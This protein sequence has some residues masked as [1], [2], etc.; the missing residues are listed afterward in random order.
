MNSLLLDGSSGDFLLVSDLPLTYEESFQDYH[1]TS[2]LPPFLSESIVTSQG[3]LLSWEVEPGFKVH[4]LSKHGT[5][6]YFHAEG[7]VDRGTWP[8]TGFNITV[9]DLGKVLITG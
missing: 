2:G 6:I 7:G 4:V 5:F 1:N 9:R 3:L 8:W